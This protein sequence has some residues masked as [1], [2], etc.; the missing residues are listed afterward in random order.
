MRITKIRKETLKKMGYGDLQSTPEYKLY[1]KRFVYNR[2]YNMTMEVDYILSAEGNNKP[3]Y[4][5][6]ID[7]NYTYEEAMENGLTDFDSEQEFND[8][9]EQQKEVYQWFLMDNRLIYQLKERNEVILNE[10]Y[11][12]RQCCGQMIDMDGVI[13]EIFKEWFLGMSVV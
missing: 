8:S 1:C 9:F 4:S 10:C 6:D 2:S 13:I 5:E 7:L 12:G 3:F 11:W